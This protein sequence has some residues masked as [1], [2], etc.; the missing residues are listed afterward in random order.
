MTGV[1]TCLFRSVDSDLSLVSLSIYKDNNIMH[2]VFD[3]NGEVVFNYSDKD[4]KKI[5][6]SGS[7]YF[8][9]EISNASQ[10]KKLLNLV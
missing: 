9:G 6:V 10:I 8:S 5:R 7:S 1:Q 3:K 4:M 2:L